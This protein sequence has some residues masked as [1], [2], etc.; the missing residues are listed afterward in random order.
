MKRSSLS[1]LVTEFIIQCKNEELAK[2][3]V[4]EIAGIFKVSESF[5]SRKFR[6][7]KN[8]TV[9]KY[10]YRERMFRAASLLTGDR[11]LTINHKIPL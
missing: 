11:Q 2:L 3:S 6:E 5:L 10:I 4:A 7:D 9:G 8:I 1:D